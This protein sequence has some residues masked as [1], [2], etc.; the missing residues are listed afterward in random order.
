VFK[1]LLAQTDGE[2]ALEKQL[3]AEEREECLAEFAAELE[4]RDTPEERARRALE[5]ADTLL[6]EA[7]LTLASV[8]LQ[9]RVLAQ[10]GAAQRWSF[11]RSDSK[12]PFN[13]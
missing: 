10:S 5:E 4:A 3:K 9:G 12:I 7:S 13:S 2:Q 6:V 8:P 11:S 1:D